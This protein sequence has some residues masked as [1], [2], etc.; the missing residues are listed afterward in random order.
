MY[1]FSEERKKIIRDA[2]RILEDARSLVR[3][4]MI[5]YKSVFSFV[6]LLTAKGR[7][8]GRGYY[9]T[10]HATVY[11]SA[12]RNGSRNEKSTVPLQITNDGQTK[13]IQTR[14]RAD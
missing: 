4:N 8:A 1:F 7:L 10:L 2:E 13:R 3:G 6:T 9:F 12:A 5:V 14:H 11:F